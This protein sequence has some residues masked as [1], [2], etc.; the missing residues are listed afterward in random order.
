[1]QDTFC[2]F[3]RARRRDY[4]ILSGQYTN[5]T[6]RAAGAEAAGV[7]DGLSALGRARRRDYCILSGQ[8]TNK[9]GRA[10]GAEAAGCGTGF[11]RFRR[12]RR[13]DYCLLSGQYTN[14]TGRAA[15]AEAAGCGT[16][17][18][19]FG[20]RGGGITVYCPDNIQI[21]RD[22]PRERRPLGAGR[23]FRALACAAAGLLYIVRTIYK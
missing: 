15:G 20:V 19:R 18:P 1:M 10:A 14:K 22:V 8:Y 16:G 3:R 23:A 7:R 11:P 9:T 2:Q 6:G 13:R 5:K 12:A 21:R 4:C 17:F